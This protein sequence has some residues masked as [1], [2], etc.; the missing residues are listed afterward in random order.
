MNRLS[1]VH[2]APSVLFSLT[3]ISIT[4]GP[5]MG[6][7]I[8]L[9]TFRTWCIVS[10]SNCMFVDCRICS[11]HLAIDNRS[12]T[13]QKLSRLWIEFLRA[14]S[15]L[16]RYEYDK[17]VPSYCKCRFLDCYIYM[18]MYTTICNFFH[19]LVLQEYW[20]LTEIIIPLKPVL[21]GVRIVTLSISSHEQTQ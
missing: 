8:R 19:I 16:K 2:V 15:G 4:R 11:N 10:E 6:G 9:F 14:I 20:V 3:P 12:L 5:M 13:V 7:L 1:N 17:H 18:Y 21:G